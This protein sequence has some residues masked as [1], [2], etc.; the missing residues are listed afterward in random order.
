MG[1]DWDPGEFPSIPE[2]FVSIRDWVTDRFGVEEGIG[3]GFH[4][5]SPGTTLVSFN[6]EG[7]VALIENRHTVFYFDATVTP[8]LS[9]NPSIWPTTLQLSSGVG[10]EK[11]YGEIPALA[12][13]L[14][15]NPLVIFVNA[16]NLPALNGFMNFFVGFHYY[17]G[18]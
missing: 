5:G 1:L 12:L 3:L 15:W 10:I 2:Y 13:N 18:Q 9:S 14:Q 16:P 8:E 6:T 11:V 4:P 7:M 17:F